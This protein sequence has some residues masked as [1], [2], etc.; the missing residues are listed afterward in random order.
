MRVNSP[1]TGKEVMMKD[2]EPIVSKTDLKGR[3]TFVNKAFVDLSGFTEKEL[4]GQAHNIVR[5]PDMPEEAFADLWKTLKEERPWTGYV[6]NRCKN[7]DHYWVKANAAPIFENGTVVGY[8]SVREKPSREAVAAHEA[9]YESIRKGQSNLVVVD[10][11]GLPN[12]PLKLAMRNITI[13]QKTLMG[14]LIVL[15]FTALLGWSGLSNLGAASRSSQAVYDEHI[16]ELETLKTVADLY[17]VNIVDTVHKA[18]GGSLTPAAA[19]GNIAE[20]KKGIAKAWQA[21]SARPDH[22]PEVR[23]LIQSANLSMKT[24]DAGIQKAEDLLK[25]NDAAGLATFA[26]NALY[27]ALDPVGNDVSKISELLLK[28]AKA[29]T[30]RVV[31]DTSSA[32]T[33]MM[34]MLG[35]AILAGMWVAGWI[36]G[37]IRTKVASIEG[38][39][40]QFAEGRLD[41]DIP[42]THHDEMTALLNAAKTMQVKLG[43]DMAETR[44]RAEEMTRIKIALDNVSTGVMIANAD[45]NII[46][47]NN[48]VQRILK[49]AESDLRKVL[50]TFNA[51]NLVGQSIDQFHKNPRHQADLLGNLRQAATAE[52]TIGAR[53]MQVIANPV[54][55]ENGDRLGSVA[56]WKDRTAELAATEREAKLAQENLRVRIALDNVST[57]VMIADNER[58]IIYVNASVQ[59]ILKAAEEDLRKVLPTFN[60]DKLLGQSIDQFHKNPKH[61]ADMLAALAKT[62]VAELTI[63]SR[64]MQVVANPVIDRDGA[65]LG[66][67]AEWKDRTAELAAAE[68]E[69]KLADENLRVRI[70]LDN[71]S[72]GVMIA[73]SQR[74]IIYINNSVQQILKAAEADLRKVLP[75]FNADRLIG[76]SIDQFHKNP[77]HQAD[78]LARLSTTHVAQLAIGE[79]HMQVTA[80]PVINAQGERLGAVAEWK[81]RTAEI[82]TE[83]EVAMVVQAAAAGDFSTRIDVNGKDGFFRSLGEQINTLVNTADVGL[84]DVSRVLSGLAQGDLTERIN[85]DYQGL[86]D[87][88]KGDCNRSME[89]LSKT[90]GEV[91]AAADALTGAAGQVSSTSQSLSQAASEQAASVEETSASM[92]VMSG[93]VRQN[94]DNAKITDGMATK[95]A[96]EASEGG[97]AVQQTVHAM[98]QIA[99]KVSIIDDIAYQT[100]LLALNAAI[101]AARAGEHGKGFAVVAAEV[102]KLAERSQVAAQE[103]GQLATSSVDMAERAGTLLTQMVPSIRKTS[104]LVQEISAASEEQNEGINQMSSAMGQLSQSTQQNASASEELAA[105]AEEMSGQAEQLQQLMSFF[106]DSDGSGSSGMPM[107]TAMKPVRRG[108]PAPRAAL[109][110]AMNRRSSDAQSDSGTYVH[111]PVT[112]DESSFSRF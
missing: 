29:A 17:A 42:I 91:R 43:N 60:A 50:P 112:V 52:L 79:R 7:G 70:A 26:N 93:S 85:G 51:D 97:Q 110:N 21:Y 10:G 98:K 94:S 59:R 9:A 40:R 46:Y 65:R 67:V 19:L 76:Q 16:R 95:A 25:A 14:M 30:E 53:R 61:Q 13:R 6:K 81:D 12:S 92:Q 35:L 75:T 84:N 108:G 33:T 83:R 22:A 28:S 62:H 37:T 20:A 103:I 36:G 104:E 68:R 27:P 106:R 87:Q 49:E 34:V 82:Q 18:R 58:N 57:G 32:Q 4:M 11:Q 73:N 69:A 72:T 107:L 38:Y 102:R 45:R 66:A 100:N 90:I 44:I 96:E 55:A 71:V 8:M 74:E 56:E 24:A 47:V 88:L 99:T 31:A 1:V 23:A 48:S 86:F 111:G 2:G 109:G 41:V 15:L 63:G 64:R 3:I 77:K 80:N 78:M 105:T 54:I 89:V 101:E 39:F 5:H